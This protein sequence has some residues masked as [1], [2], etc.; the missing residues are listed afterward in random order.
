MK[1]TR[2][3]IKIISNFVD[4]DADKKIQNNEMGNDLISNGF[5]TVDLINFLC[6]DSEA[7]E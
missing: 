1:I 3:I 4:D 5:T 7:A 2:V 6:I